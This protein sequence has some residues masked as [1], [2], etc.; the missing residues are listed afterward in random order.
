MP[1]PMRTRSVTAQQVRTYLGKAEEFLDAAIAELNADRPIAATSLAIHAAMNAA[2]AVC[3]T[4]TGQR[5]AGQDHDEVLRLLAE[6]GKDGAALRKDL[7]R[8]LP[9]K[10]KSEYEPEEVSLSTA[11]KAV[12]RAKRC[13][14]LARRVVG[15]GSRD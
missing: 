6:A 13:V 11:S 3:G 10:T 1:K 5:A 4:R 7:R 12:E 15:T 2:D 14:T 9:L 8:L